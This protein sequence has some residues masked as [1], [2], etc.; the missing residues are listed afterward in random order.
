MNCELSKGKFIHF[1]EGGR[2]ELL[3]EVLKEIFLS[4]LSIDEAKKKSFAEEEWERMETRG[5][6]N[7]AFWQAFWWMSYPKTGTGEFVYQHHWRGLTEEEAKWDE[8]KLMTTDRS[9]HGDLRLSTE[10]REELLSPAARKA[11]EGKL[12]WL[13]GVTIFLGEVADNAKKKHFD[14]LIDWD[15]K[16]NLQ[17]T[18]KPWQPTAWL[19]IGDP[20]FTIPPAGVGATENKWAKFFK[21]S[22]GKYYAGVWREHAFEI[23]LEDLEI[24]DKPNLSGRMLLLY[25]PFGGR[26]EWIV[27]RPE[28][29]TPYAEQKKL[30]EVV[31]ELKKKGQKYLWWNLP[32]D[33]GQLI[34]IE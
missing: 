28:D 30:D 34:K 29:Q 15:P 33:P 31:K 8:E 9:V 11:A 25:A 27:D 16:D 19:K 22:A 7:I 4:Q 6:R 12:T 24:E 13:W 5:E 14:R 32:G 20:P 3:D 17:F 2:R 23:F 1:L 10:L 21:K 26:R 18:W